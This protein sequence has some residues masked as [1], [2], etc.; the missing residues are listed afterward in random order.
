[1][2]RSYGG[3]QCG[4]WEIGEAGSRNTVETRTRELGLLR[5]EKGEAVDEDEKRKIVAGGRVG[6]PYPGMGS[7]WERECLGRGRGCLADLAGLVAG[8]IA[9]SWS[10]GLDAPETDALLSPD[11]GRAI[12]QSWPATRERGG[13]R[14][15]SSHLAR[16]RREPRAARACICGG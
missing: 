8:N 2:C 11:L 7:G 6:I 3:L 15:R 1:M 4:S 16:A 13:A 5:A 9:G 14:V 10:V 12:K